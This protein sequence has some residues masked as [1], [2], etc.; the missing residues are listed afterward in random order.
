MLISQDRNCEQPVFNLL[1]DMY[2]ESLPLWMFNSFSQCDYALGYALNWKKKRKLLLL[3][4]TLIHQKVVCRLPGGIYMY[5]RKE[6]K[7][8]NLLAFNDC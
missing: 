6:K 7:N 5:I 3:I 2:I 1:L 4:L 8:I